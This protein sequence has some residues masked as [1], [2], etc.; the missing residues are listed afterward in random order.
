MLDA[1]AKM[2]LILVNVTGEAYGAPAIVSVLMESVYL[3][4]PCYWYKLTRVLY[5]P[6]DPIPGAVYQEDT[7]SMLGL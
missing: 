3:F 6:P 1:G 7:L 5:V 2:T 4:C